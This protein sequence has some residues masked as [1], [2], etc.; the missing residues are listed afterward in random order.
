MA[1]LV[2]LSATTG[3]LEHVNIDFAA[4]PLNRLFNTAEL[5][6]WHHRMDIEQ[7]MCNFGKMLSIWDGVFGTYYLPRDREIGDVGI[8]ATAKPVPVGF[9]GQCLY[10][11]RAP[12]H[13]LERG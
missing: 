11:F 9:W 6:R 5:H 12:F 8:D 3:L 10:P 13:A 1:L 7:A 4:G 2:T